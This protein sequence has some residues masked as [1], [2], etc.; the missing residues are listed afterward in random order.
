MLPSLPTGYRD[1]STTWRT[2]RRSDST[3]TRAPTQH[4]LAL[5]INV[6][7]SPPSAR[8]RAPTQQALIQHG[9][10]LRLLRLI[11]D[12]RSDSTR[13]QTLNQQGPPALT[14]PSH[15]GLR[16]GSCSFPL[17]YSGGEATCSHRLHQDRGRPRHLSVARAA[18]LLD[19]GRGH[20]LRH[21]RSS[22]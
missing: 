7:Y 16:P 8:T 4:E 18:G 21:S 17:L 10:H 9:L 3:W 13:T 12:T 5:S 11:T 19:L 1:R 14:P 2:G 22:F 6:D 15:H 20:E